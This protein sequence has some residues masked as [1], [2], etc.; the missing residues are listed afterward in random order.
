DLIQSQMP[1][2]KC[3]DLSGDSVLDIQDATLIN[4]CINGNKSHAGGS[5]H[6]HC[7]FPR[8]ILN[9]N[10]TIS[11]SISN[12][13][14]NNNYVDVEVKSQDANIK[15]YQFKM[16]GIKISSVVSLISPVTFPVD[17]RFIAS[18]NEVFA[19]SLEDS[20]LRRQNASQP[21]IRIYFSAIID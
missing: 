19:I 6:N 15:S 21:L 1:S 16:N 7:N 17:A 2:S 18:T 12:I 13:D 14:F 11:L 10:D 8:N 4:W 9:P 3:N 20:S 5:I